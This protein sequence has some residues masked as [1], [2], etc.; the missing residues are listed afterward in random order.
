MDGKRDWPWT[1]AKLFALALALV[2]AAMLAWQ[3]ATVL[4]LLFAAILLAVLLSALAGLIERSTPVPG[5]WAVGLA[6]LMV[7][8]VL[9]SFV[10]LMGAQ[11]VAQAASLAADL[12]ALVDA[13][14][15]RLGLSGLGAWLEERIAGA[16]A[17]GGLVR[18]VAGYSTSLVNVAAH[19][20][21][22]VA[23]GIYLALDPR[24][25]R[26]GAILLVPRGRRPEARETLLTIG[27]ALR[28]WLA[29]QLAAMALVG[30]LTTLG[31]LWIGIPSAMALGLLA[32]LLEFVPYVGPI[33]AAAPALALGLA[34][35]PTTA[36]WVAGLY[37]AIQQAEG[38]LITPLVQQ[39]TV[40]LPPVVTIFSILSFGVL[41]G[42][43]GVVLATPLA[44]VCFVLVKRLWVREVVGEDVDVP[45]EGEAVRAGPDRP[46][47]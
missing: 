19:V 1:A 46:G 20:V 21:I 2:A 9:A 39:R 23:A 24:R 28:L 18:S 38:S 33:L 3:L 10:A 29:G 14:E 8:G 40:D 22:V 45:G 47:D 30:V 25:Y 7:G 34:E 17:G 6:C 42:P 44:V 16:L 12:P 26:E 41:L 32:G 31:L 43:L 4:L 35:G 37:L 5:R 15:A 36:L 27:G 11:I 13:A